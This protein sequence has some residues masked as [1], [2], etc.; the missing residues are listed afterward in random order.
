MC[1]TFVLKDTEE[2]LLSQDRKYHCTSIL[3]FLWFKPHVWQK[4]VSP[5]RNP[6]LLCTILKKLSPSTIKSHSTK[7]KWSKLMQKNMHVEPKQ[8]QTNETI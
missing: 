5:G 3:V 8:T 2:N 1:Y 7:T 6:T 4:Q